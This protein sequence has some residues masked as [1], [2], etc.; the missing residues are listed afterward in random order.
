LA[1]RQEKTSA[2]FNALADPTRRRILVRLSK[3]GETRVT[4]LA[5]PFAMSL[6]SISKHLRVLEK[7]LLIRRRRHGRVHIIQANIE[8]M[9]EA[10]AWITH[11]AA[12][13]A[14]GLDTLDELLRNERKEGKR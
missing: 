9:R 10:Q 14:F 8:G 6:P 11:C 1:K 13:W 5:E 3:H 2:V 7:A 4:D 12:G